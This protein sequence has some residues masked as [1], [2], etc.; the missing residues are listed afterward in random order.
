MGV[1]DKLSA[2]RDTRRSLDAAGRS[3]DAPASGLPVKLVVF[4]NASLGFVKLELR[5]AGFLDRASIS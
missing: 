4:K 2:C 5:A 3:L 1:G